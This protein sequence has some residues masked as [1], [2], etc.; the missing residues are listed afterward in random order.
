M[1]KLKT[2]FLLSVLCVFLSPIL[3]NAQVVKTGI[4]TGTIAEGP[5]QP[6]PGVEVTI[7]SPALM[8]PQ[9]SR[10]TNEKGSF[11]FTFLPPGLY[12]LSAKLIGFGSYKT[13]NITIL[14][15]MTTELSIQ[16]QPAKLETEVVVVS[17]APIIAVENTKLATNIDATELKNLPVSRSVAAVLNLVPGVTGGTVFNSGSRENSWNID[18][19]QV[20]DPGSGSGMS[21]SQSMD[22]YEEVQIETAGHPAELGNAGGAVVNVITKSGGNTFSGEGSLYFTNSDLQAL[23]IKGTPVKAPTTQTL[24]SYGVNFSLGG[25][26]IKDKLWFFLSSG[27][28]PSKTRLAGFSEDTPYST[29]NPMVKL[30]YQPNAN[31]RFSF[32][33]NYNRTRNPFMFAGQFTRP[34]ATFNTTIQAYAYNANWLWTISPNTI[35]EVRGFSLYRP[36]NYLS[37]TQSV[38]YYDYATGVQSGSANDCIQERLRWQSNA[39]LSQYV[40]GM[41]GDHEF[42]VGFEYERGESRNASNYFPDQYGMVMYD[43]WEGIPLYAYKYVPARVSAQIDPYNQ[44][45][46]FAQDTWK[47]SKHLVANIGLRYNFVH[48]YNPPQLE[49]K[50]SVP[51]KD[52]KNFEPRLSLGIDPLGDGKTGIKVGY[53]R[54]AHMMWTWFYSLNPNS[55]KLYMYE[56]WAPGVFNLVYESSPEMYTLDPDLQRP[57][58]EELLLSVDR[59]ITRDIGF[60]ASYIN[61]KTKKTVTYSNQNLGLEWYVP[62]TITNP[63]T[64]QPMT[65]YR[66]KPDAPYESNTLYNNDPRA[67]NNYQGVIVE[68]DKKLSHNYSFRFSYTLGLTKANALTTS[69][70]MG[71]GGF[72]NPN[73]SMYDFQMTDDASHVFK[74]QGIW[75]APLG[76]ILSTNYLGRSGAQYAPY[77]TYNLGG[78]QGV[79]SFLADKPSSRRMPFL[80]YFDLRIGKDFNIRDSKLSVFVDLYNALNA[81]TTTSLYTRIGASTP[82]GKTLGI[83]SGRLAQFGV[84]YQF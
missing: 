14:L 29:V 70:M 26:I 78:Q 4:L 82:F 71:L 46:G 48:I 42:K 81:N 53:A 12:T 67:K 21:A 33:F 36:T 40:D 44:F 63:L 16:M 56:V 61:R 2:I 37:R 6:L 52:W 11:R 25:P 7:S 83:Q 80:H 49:Q 64:G 66:L 77:F 24:Y 75:Y 23:N 54:Y 79:V 20:T 15:N 18:G 62:I 31:H 30:S 76:I 74:F 28:T 27:Y 51:L 65:A 13:E 47:I 10:V 43:T 59:A 55:A 9:L 32:S 60:K 84:R 8:T 69:S 17:A 41:A 50:V 39:T 45:A 3:G 22:A 5:N 58:V 72:D 73:F 34:E 1:N 38:I 68:L 35:L 19:V 57:Y